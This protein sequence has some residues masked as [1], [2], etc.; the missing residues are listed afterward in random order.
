MV[1]YSQLNAGFRALSD[2]VRRGVLERLGQG[3]A[4]I[5]DLADS[6]G[7]SLTGIN[8]HVQVLDAAGLVTTLKV[9]RV[10][11]CRLGPNKLE[12]QAMWIGNYRQM[13]EGRFDR[14]DAFLERT[15]GDQP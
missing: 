5:S 8:K 9:G 2:P 11:L 10:R 14:L 7:M 3:D 1:Q 15:K 4:S 12:D 6:F 13:L